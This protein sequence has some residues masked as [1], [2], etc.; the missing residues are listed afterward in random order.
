MGNGS[1][2]MTLLRDDASS[3]LLQELLTSPQRGV[4][5]VKE[6]ID[7]VLGTKLATN[8]EQAKGAETQP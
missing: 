5:K 2:V 7:R 1:F 6:L 3:S 8:A 4:E